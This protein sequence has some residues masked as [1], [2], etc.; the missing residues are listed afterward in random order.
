[1]VEK[2]HDYPYC[3]RFLI[4]PASGSV[5][6]GKAVHY[7]SSGAWPSGHGGAKMSLTIG[8]ASDACLGYRFIRSS[9]SAR[10]AR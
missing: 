9:A 5:N 6:H 1:M 3:S 7:P 10:L 8:R 4:P 2:A